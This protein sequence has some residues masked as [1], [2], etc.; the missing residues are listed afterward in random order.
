MKKNI[1]GIVSRRLSISIKAVMLSCVLGLLC[2]CKSEGKATSENADMPEIPMQQSDSTTS[3][4]SLEMLRNDGMKQ[5]SYS[6]YPGVFLEILNLAE[7]KAPVD[8][9]SLKITNHTDSIV[10][11]GNW[12]GLQTQSKNGKWDMVNIDERYEGNDS[13]IYVVWESI[14]YLLYPQTSHE[15]VEKPWFYGKN[16]VPGHYRLAKDFMIGE[17]HNTQDTVYVEFDIK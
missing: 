2:S 16:L 7:M 4:V 13:V 6:T 9:I 1:Y 15:K 14:G 17:N 11:Y 10:T 12:F 8:S 5:K 3:K